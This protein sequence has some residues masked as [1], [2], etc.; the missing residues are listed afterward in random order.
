[1]KIAETQFCW[2]QLTLL[3]QKSLA[4]S[5]IS[6]SDFSVMDILGSNNLSILAIFNI[7]PCFTVITDVLLSDTN[8]CLEDET[9]P[10]GPIFRVVCDKLNSSEAFHHDSLH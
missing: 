2:L 9:D 3:M 7:L 4:Q 1:M 8:D 6:S 10:P 5:S